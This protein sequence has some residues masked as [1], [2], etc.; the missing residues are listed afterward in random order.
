MMTRLRD[1]SGRRKQM[2]QMAFPARGVEPFSI[3]PGSRPVQ[4]RLDAPPKP[5]RRLGLGLPYRL[6]HGHDLRQPNV[7]DLKRPQHRI[8]AGQGVAPLFGM[9][10]VAPAGLVRLDVGLRR[11]LKGQC[12]CGVRFQAACRGPSRRDG[13][14]ASIDLLA[15]LTGTP[16]CVRQWHIW[17]ATQSHLAA[18]A[19]DGHAEQPASRRGRLHLQR[20]PCHTTYKVQPG[21]DQTTNGSR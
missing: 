14:F 1:L 20:Q 2:I 3:S 6:K 7:P 9:L 21:I 17:I 10:C 13:I 16:S 8:G 15:F 12:L 19:C 11:L 18:L 4:N 5:R